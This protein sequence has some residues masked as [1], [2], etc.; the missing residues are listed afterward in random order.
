MA[1]AE[2][3]DSTAALTVLRTVA[4]VRTQIFRESAVAG[5]AQSKMHS[6]VALRSFA[7]SGETR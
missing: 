3:P 7:P 5:W 1:T 6:S 2:T 4:L